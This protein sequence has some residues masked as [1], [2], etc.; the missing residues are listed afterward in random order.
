MKKNIFFLWFNILN[1]FFLVTLFSYLFCPYILSPFLEMFKSSDVFA[2]HPLK[3][4]ML[5]GAIILLFS[6]AANWVFY[7]M[8]NK[9]FFLISLLV[10]L[11]GMVLTMWFALA[12]VPSAVFAFVGYK[13]MK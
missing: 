11:G 2:G 12:F 9:K 7:I 1:S 13:K 10:T 6:V 3:I 4:V 5:V 8:K